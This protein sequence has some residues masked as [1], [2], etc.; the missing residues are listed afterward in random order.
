MSISSLNPAVGAL[1]YIK[2]GSDASATQSELTGKADKQRRVDSVSEAVDVGGDRRRGKDRRSALAQSVVNPA[3]FMKKAE[4]S[5]RQMPGPQ[6]LSALIKQMSGA[7]QDS[8]QAQI[9]NIAV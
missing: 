9:V 3:L 1:P 7:E 4:D 6:I 2:L 5:P 8:G